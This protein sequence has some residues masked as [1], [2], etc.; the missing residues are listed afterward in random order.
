M[1]EQKVF[2]GKEGAKELFR[3]LKVEIGKFQSFQTAD[4]AGADNHPDV[5]SPKTNIIYLVAVSGTTGSDIYKE[6]IWSE[7]EGEEGEW[8]CIGDTSLDLSGYAEKVSG[9]TS[10][11]FAGLDSNG[12]LTDSGHKHSD[13]AS[14]SQGAAADSAVQSVRI[15]SGENLK[16]GTT[17]TIPLAASGVNGAMS[18]SDKSKLDNIASGA[19]VNVIEHVN[20]GEDELVPVNKT[21]TIPYAEVDIPV[22]EVTIGSHTYK[23][24]TMPD[25][26]EWLAENLDYKW[27]GLYLNLTSDYSLPRAQYYDN[28]EADYGIDGTYKCGLLYNWKAAQYIN[29]NRATICPGWHVPSREEWAALRKSIT[30]NAGTSIKAK[31]KSVTSNWPSGWNGDDTYE[32]KAL[33]SGYA[34]VYTSNYKEFTGRDSYAYFWTSTSYGTI[35]GVKNSYYYYLDDRT[36]IDEDYDSD[37][38]GMSIRLVKDTPVPSEPTYTGGLMTDSMVE[39]LATLA[40]VAT[41]GSYN[42]LTTKAPVFAGSTAGLVPAATPGDSSKA[43]RGDGT[44][45]D[46]S[47]VTVS[48]DSVNEE[49]HLDFSPQVNNGGN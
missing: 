3:R 14:S 2:V 42:D 40:T 25:G 29:D 1:S 11:N 15:G 23:T 44:W 30:G 28:D 41:T 24:V 10:G 32:F 5:D 34:A 46:V 47:S 49:L 26:K 38:Y 45:G 35:N 8:E 19:Q 13:Y 43:L 31:N 37:A 27:Q 4:P 48:Y 20:A 39:K 36:G 9:A 12:N 7:P 22:H 18:G 6:W 33:P 21:V 17:V 16:S